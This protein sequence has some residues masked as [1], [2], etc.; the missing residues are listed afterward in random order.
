MDNTVNYI[1]ILKESLYKKV[2]VLDEILRLNELQKESVSEDKFNEDKFE[3]S[4]EKKDVCIA[5]LNKLDSG[6]ESVFKHVKEK[7]DE[8]PELYK[9]DV[10]EF[11]KLISEITEKSMEVQLSEKRNEKLVFG[12]LSEERT[13]IRQSKNAN[14]VA[15]DYY[16]NMSKVNVVEPQFLDKKK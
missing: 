14:R 6:F 8:N 13:K 2:E 1:S 7:I 4:I 10:E 9:K 11:Q 12:K 15:T 3:E 16:K 5:E